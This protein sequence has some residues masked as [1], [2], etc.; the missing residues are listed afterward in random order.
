MTIRDKK[1]QKE[2]KPVTHDGEPAFVIGF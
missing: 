1:S 2:E